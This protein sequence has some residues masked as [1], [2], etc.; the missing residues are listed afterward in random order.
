MLHRRSVL[1]LLGSLVLAAVAAPAVT[2]HRVAAAAGAATDLAWVRQVRGP[3]DDNSLAVDTTPDG[4]VYWAGS[5]RGRALFGVGAATATRTV[6]PARGAFVTSMSQFGDLRWVRTFGGA[7][8]DTW[9]MAARPGGGAVVVGSFRGVL[10]ADDGAVLAAES[11]QTSTF[12]VAFTS[13][14]SIDWVRTAV[15]APGT[16]T[17]SVAYGVDVGADGT[18]A[19][20]GS[21]RGSADLGVDDAPLVV[22]ATAL[23]PFVAAYAS[24]GTPRWV[25]APTTDQ[26]ICTDAVVLP[27]G[28]VVAVGAFMGAF[29]AGPGV[30]LNA[31]SGIRGF[32]TTF[33]G[34]GQALWASP[35]SDGGAHLPRAVAASPDGATLAVAGLALAP[36]TLVDRS[37]PSPGPVDGTLV[38][39]RASDGAATWTGAL[40]GPGAEAL[41]DVSVNATGDV[42]AVGVRSA[43]STPI[44]AVGATP[45]VEGVGDVALIGWDATGAVAVNGRLPGSLAAAVTDSPEGPLVAATVRASVTVGPRTI[46]SSGG[47]DAVLLRLGAIAN[48]PPVVADSAMHA[49]FAAG[50][51]ITVHGEDPDGDD[52]A[53][54]VVTGPAHGQLS[55]TPPELTYTSVAGFVGTDTVAVRATDPWGASATA[56]VTVDVGANHAPLVAA[57]PVSTTAGDAA[58]VVAT[59]TDADGDETSV[60]ITSA[61]AHGTIARVGGGWRY[62][63]TPGFVGVDGMTVTATDGIGGRTSAHI[64]LTVLA[65]GSNRPPRR[66]ESPDATTMPGTPV[67]V[68]VAVLDPDGDAVALEVVAPPAA[69]TATAIPGGFR[70]LP[71]PDRYRSVTVAVRATDAHGASA[72]FDIPVHVK[73]PNVVVVLTDDQTL[74]QLRWLPD[75]SAR[76]AAAG[77]TFTNAVVSNSECCPSR[78]TLLTGQYSHNHGLVTTALPTGGASRFVDTSTLPVWLQRD[79]YDTL[80]AGKYLNDYGTAVPPEYVPPGWT[81]WYAL[82]DPAAYSYLGGRISDDGVV[83]DLPALPDHYTTD[84]LADHV[85]DAVDAHA[86]GP[87]PLF[88]LFTPVAPHYGDFL[89]QAV[90]AARHAGSRSG[91]TAP[92]GPSFNEADVSDKPSLLRTKPL[93]SAGSVAAIDREYQAAA[94]SLAAVDEAVV[95]IWDA[96]ER[97]GELDQTL[98]VFSSDNGFLYG[99]HRIRSGKSLPYEP[100]VRVPLLAAG[101]GFPAGAVAPQPVANIDLAPTVAA[102]A[103]FE[104]GHQVD[105]LDLRSLASEPTV[106]AHRAILLENGPYPGRRRYWAVRDD[107][108][109]TISWSTGE[110][111][112]YDLLTDPGQSTNLAG[113]AAHR[114]RMLNDAARLKVLKTCVGATCD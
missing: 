40:T 98:L 29:D 17:S 6:A 112:L 23:A 13:H 66:T 101:P 46:T 32:A 104:P 18:V 72:T 75:T 83:V 35:L 9:S 99:E 19:V 107:R 91:A 105:G 26:G 25:R 111:E 53:W 100:A 20:A 24:D 5:F 88:A 28:R 68:T 48:R 103:G 10:R 87:R 50:R 78:A 43:T 80:L 85:V 84:L 96:L 67:D 114:L 73:P 55:G 81:D 44:G 42:A 71:G 110:W 45:P 27:D 60:E 4:S 21:I 31:G 11:A 54:S 1:V 37:L 93:L 36:I 39:L 2:Q 56:T 63:P 14:G 113:S 30:G 51:P 69:G 97:R 94:E 86:G 58:P 109:V 7:T 59:V 76:L 52:L 74:E 34:D 102:A 90:P 3:S 22:E 33:D 92:R 82:A 49:S 65:A 62:Q 70:Y 95:R 77:T 38:S 64:E 79:G 8:T 57:D 15:A 108:W 41:L 106:G 12:V 61:P 47:D 89:N 16:T